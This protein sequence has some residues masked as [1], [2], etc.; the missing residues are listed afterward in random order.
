VIG[1]LNMNHIIPKIGALAM[2]LTSTQ[3]SAQDVP[4]WYPQ[5]EIMGMMDSCHLVISKTGPLN[6]PSSL[7]SNSADIK[8]ADSGAVLS[9]EEWTE[10]TAKRH[11]PPS[12]ILIPTGACMYQRV[13]AYASDASGIDPKKVSE[14]GTAESAACLPLKKRAASERRFQEHPGPTGKTILVGLGK[15]AREGTFQTIATY[16][17]DQIRAQA[18]QTQNQTSCIGT[19]VDIPGPG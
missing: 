5:H 1:D 12:A 3:I 2:T 13:L 8:V 6:L 9:V 17:W 7:K 18:R 19:H 4:I 16:D 15:K 14:A 10:K 11:G